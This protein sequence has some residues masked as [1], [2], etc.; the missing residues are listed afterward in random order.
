MSL[1]LSLL[2]TSFLSQDHCL[3]IISLYSLSNTLIYSYI[4]IILAPFSYIPFIHFIQP[5]PLLLRP[6]STF[7]LHPLP[8]VSFILITVL[9]SFL[10]RNQI[11][12]ENIY[13]LEIHI[14]LF[15]FPLD[16]DSHSLIPT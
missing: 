11:R 15:I 9:L 3:L 4:L 6:F 14:S 1:H 8:I 2:F 10:S 5:I 16:L 12:L 13:L 7:H